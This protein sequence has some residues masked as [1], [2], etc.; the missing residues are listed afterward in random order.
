MASDEEIHF[1]SEEDEPATNSNL[2]KKLKRKAATDDEEE[3]E[4]GRPEVTPRK[5][6]RVN[7]FQDMAFCMSFESLEDL[8]QLVAVLVHIQQRQSC[9]VA[10][11][12]FQVV[13]DQQVEEEDSEVT[14]FTGLSST[15]F[16]KS[17]M[18]SGRVKGTLLHYDNTVDTTFFIRVEDL[19]EHLQYIPADA[20]CEIFKRKGTHQL[21][22]SVYGVTKG[23]SNTN[24]MVVNEVVTEHDSDPGH[25][26]DMKHNYPMSIHAS[27]V[28]N[29]IMQ[30]ST[31]KSEMLRVTVYKNEN[32]DND[33]L[34][35]VDMVFQ[36]TAFDLASGKGFKN[37]HIKRKSDSADNEG[38]FMINPL[39]DDGIQDGTLVEKLGFG[40]NVEML[41]SVAMALKN[42][43]QIHLALGLYK[44]S[45]GEEFVPMQEFMDGM[46]PESRNQLAFLTSA[47]YLGINLGEGGKIQM[48]IPSVMAD[49]DEE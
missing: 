20:V 33:E 7:R 32:T 47:L 21:M 14:S 12:L 26:P 17:T 23:V 6:A 45:D 25:F 48:L 42:H 39:V 13:N 28:K 19:S 35:D 46:D 18:V 8:R 41:K 43:H 5:R 11:V 16:I 34:R 22:I 9:S 3:E 37:R 36:F 31:N 49:D 24:E 10:G 15:L 1:S 30:A 44:V 29:L 4:E 38:V 2:F 27:V 40:Y